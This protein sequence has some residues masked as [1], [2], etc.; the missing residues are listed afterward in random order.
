MNKKFIV[1][2]VEFVIE[3]I[4]LQVWMQLCFDVYQHGL[5]AEFAEF[6]LEHPDLNWLEIDRQFRNEYDI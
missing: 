6:I 1:S 3:Q 2:F 4:N 5:H